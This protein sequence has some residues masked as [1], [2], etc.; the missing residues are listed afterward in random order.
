VKVATHADPPLPS[1]AM[2][3]GVIPTL[4]DVRAAASTIAN[5]VHRTPVLSSATLSEAVGAPVTLK[6]ELLQ[7]SGSFKVRGAFN[8]LSSLTAE[9]RTRGVIGVSAGNH[10][11]ALALAA[12]E[13]GTT[14]LVLMPPDASQAKVDATRGYGG[15]VDLE[16][17]DAA[18]MHDRMV[19]L[20]ESTG[21]VIVHPFNDP[22]V[23]AGGGTVGL[24]LVEQVANLDTVIVPVGGGGLITGVAAAVKALVPGTRVIGVEPEL[25]PSVRRALDA[26]EVV[27]VELGPTIA[28]ALKAPS[29]LPNSF[30]GC[31]TL[32]DDI[33]LVSEAELI[34]AIRFVY[35]RA[36]LA[37][38]AGA[39]AGVAALLSGRID[40]RGA[41]GVAV[42]ISGGNIAPDLLARILV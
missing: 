10:A 8:R 15:E 29:A 2:L 3:R 41:S 25:A 20:A 28:D 33:V 24:E 32:V 35:T 14:A 1:Y 36:K 30:E 6:A 21:R 22:A 12:R 31:R 13:L 37:C 23:Q 42:V 9:E 11:Q 16:S 26:G 38:E 27:A 34:D 7:R 40:V 5:H 18:A 17:P 4:D 19:A 39:A